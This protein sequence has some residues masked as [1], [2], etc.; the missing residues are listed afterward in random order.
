MAHLTTKATLDTIKA[1]ER[2]V[3]FHRNKSHLYFLF[4]ASSRRD[5]HLIEVYNAASLHNNF[6]VRWIIL[7]N[8][9]PLTFGSKLIE[10]FPDDSTVCGLIALKIGVEKLDYLL[11]LSLNF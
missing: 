9:N 3:D 1:A 5:K 11:N 4:P 10:N 7:I 2:L 8:L 6:S